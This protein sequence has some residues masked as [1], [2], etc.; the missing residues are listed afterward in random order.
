MH[1]ITTFGTLAQPLQRL[2][3]FHDVAPAAVAALL[4]D[5]PVWQ[6]TAGTEI[7]APGDKA[8]L[9]I[10]LR[11][12]LQSVPE[13]APPGA[14]SAGARRI[15][16]GECVG[17]LAVLD[18]EASSERV[19]AIE[20]SQVL[21]IDAPTLWR[22]VDESNGV[23]RNLLRMLS[24][25]VRAANAQLR[26]RRKL[27]EFYRQMSMADALTGLHNRAWLNEHLPALVEAA[28]AEA[29]PL[30]LI[31]I[32]LDHFKRFNDVHGHVLGDHAL[33]A[34]AEAI[35]GGLRPSDFAAR[36][37]GE[38]LIVILPAATV[39]SARRVAERLCERVRQVR[40]FHDS[41]RTAPHITA[42]FGVATLEP[43][44]HAEA[45]ITAADAALYRA[46]E[47]GRNCVAV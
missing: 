35:S 28:Q 47:N 45:L 14:G 43:G 26:R 32:D 8:R 27:G 22:L 25:R 6:V 23:A 21:L 40:V 18:E 29:R 24:F 11:G 13:E 36:F 7:G 1:T 16:P 2:Q 38:E 37:G 17:E 9:V 41:A 42:S 46:K 44:Q 3:L 15:L 5:C 12:A 10:L 19:I 34:A 4:A 30:S 39:D 31:M 20:D 33:K